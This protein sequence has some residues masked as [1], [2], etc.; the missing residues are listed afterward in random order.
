ME[1]DKVQKTVPKGKIK[2][3]WAWSLAHKLITAV[4]VI[5]VIGGGY[6]YYKSHNSSS[7]QT[8]YF[9]GT[10]AKGTII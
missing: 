3:I 8:R 10:A 5:V 9:L 7:S 1:N 6:W 4:L 2:K